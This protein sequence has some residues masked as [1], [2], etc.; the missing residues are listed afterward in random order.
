MLKHKT[1][2]PGDLKVCKYTA[3]NTH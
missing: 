2:T 1:Q 3:V